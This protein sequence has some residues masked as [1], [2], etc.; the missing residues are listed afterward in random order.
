MNNVSPINKELW[1]GPDEL[2]GQMS[3]TPTRSQTISAGTGKSSDDL[4]GLY[5]AKVMMVDDEP[6]NLEVT[7]IYL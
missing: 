7:Q 2:N 3:N 5:D 1:A 4:S 6:L